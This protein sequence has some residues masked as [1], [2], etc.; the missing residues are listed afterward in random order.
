MNPVKWLGVVGI[1]FI[2]AFLAIPHLIIVSA[3]G[4]LA[5]WGAYIGYFIVAFTGN[6]PMGLQDFVAWWLRWAARSYG[7]LAGIADD[8][9][10]FEIDPAGY[11]IDAEIPR[12]ESPSKG[13]AVAGIFFVKFL[14]AIP[15]FIVLFILVFL[16]AFAAWF[17]Y[18]AV[19]FTGKLPTGIQDFVAG[20]MQWYLRVVTWVTGL[21]DE[22]PP[23]EL[24]SQAQAG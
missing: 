15:H 12:N 1:F 7:W 5:M 22:Y 20:T 14:A 19:A 8:Y 11:R 4:T 16:S 9:P 10:P 2:K 21:T 6:L 13:W 18:F 17:G 24:R 23:F 3:L